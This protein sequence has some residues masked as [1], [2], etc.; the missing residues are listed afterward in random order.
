MA[1]SVVAARASSTGKERMVHIVE[2]SSDEESGSSHE[3]GHKKSS[4]ESVSS[5]E[6]GRKKRKASKVHKTPLTIDINSDEDEVMIVT[7][8]GGSGSAVGSKRSALVARKRAATFATGSSRQ[9][10]VEDADL[11][12]ALKLQKEE[13]DKEALRVSR[14]EEKKRR[15]EKQR[16]AQI[17][18]AMAAALQREE[19]NK[20]TLE[21]EQK[22][23]AAEADRIMAMQLHAKYAPRP[24][25]PVPA[26]QAFPMP[27]TTF[28]YGAALR[29]GVPLPAGALPAGV[30]L[31]PARNPPTKAEQYRLDEVQI[32]SEEY[33]SIMQKL[34]GSATMNNPPTIWKVHQE[35]MTSMHNNMAMMYGNKT[36]LFH[37]TS[38]DRWE[39][40]CRGGFDRSWAGKNGTAF[41]KGA[42]FA[43]QAAYSVRYAQ[44]GNGVLFLCSCII[45][46]TLCQG[47]P[48]LTAPTDGSITAVDN[49]RAPSIYVLF[50]DYQAIP[51]YMIDFTAGRRLA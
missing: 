24:A 17:D 16:L 15:A 38:Q 37:G 26:L 44:A 5:Q 36:E 14:A 21:K 7:T 23:R 11:A 34:A 18:R 22:R 39:F 30:P 13:D 1:D 12:L 10:E 46:D 29:T 31:P 25:P 35:F 20:R 28:A 8:A 48:T 19:E 32:G 9:K 49:L 4:D 41:G 42:Y 6:T 33:M 45:G 51:L 27:P 43:R 3:T 50:K 2:I 47:T 40:I